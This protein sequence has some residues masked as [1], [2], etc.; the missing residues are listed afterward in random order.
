MIFITLSISPIWYVCMFP[1]AIY[2][3]PVPV[4]GTYLNQ[5]NKFNH[6]EDEGALHR[7]DTVNSP[8]IK[9]LDL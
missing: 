4:P 2:M 7:R 9:R 5:V 3:Y 8:L 6:M 1:I